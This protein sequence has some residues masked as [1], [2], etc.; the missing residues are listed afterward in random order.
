V[1]VW[2]S[3]DGDGTQRTHQRVKE[4]QTMLQDAHSKK[5]EEKAARWRAR[6][7]LQNIGKENNNA[8]LELVCVCTD[9]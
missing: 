5:E 7:Q 1:Y 8:K 4:E 2:L 6:V 9:T 3:C